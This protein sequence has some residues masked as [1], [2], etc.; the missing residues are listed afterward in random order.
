[1]RDRNDNEDIVPIQPQPP[2]PPQLERLMPSRDNNNITN[3]GYYPNQSYSRRERYGNP[4]ERSR[5]RSRSRSRQRNPNSN[6]RPF[7]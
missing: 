3:T 4:P 6:N 7:R 1:M 2:P 5:S